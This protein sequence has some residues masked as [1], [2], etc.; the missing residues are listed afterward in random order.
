MVILLHNESLM[1]MLSSFVEFNDITMIYIVID[2]MSFNQAI[3]LRCTVL[4]QKYLNIMNIPSF[5]THIY[6]GMLIMSHASGTFNLALT[7]PNL[8]WKTDTLTKTE[9][10]Q[11]KKKKFKL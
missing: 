1:W 8:C 5:L 7:K 6:V 3:P 4:F 9:L 11:N 2:Q 10:N